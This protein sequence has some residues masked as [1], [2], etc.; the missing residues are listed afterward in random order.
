MGEKA[1]CPAHPGE[2]IVGQ[3][4]HCRKGICRQCMRQYGY[5]C[6]EECRSAVMGSRED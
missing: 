3:C 1:T 2:R 5:F 6:S 4:S